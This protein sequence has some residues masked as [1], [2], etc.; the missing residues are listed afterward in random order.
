MSKKSRFFGK[1]VNEIKEIIIV[2]IY[3]IIVN[4]AFCQGG[5]DFFILKSLV[6]LA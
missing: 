2:L 5:R 1:N 4:M 3:D 6:A